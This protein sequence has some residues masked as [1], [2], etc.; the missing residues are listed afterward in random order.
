MPFCK[1]TNSTSFSKIYALT[2]C[3]LFG[4]LLFCIYGCLDVPSSYEQGYM[5]QSAEILLIHNENESGI[6][7]VPANETF[8]LKAKVTPQSLE[9]DLVFSWFSNGNEIAR[10]AIYEYTKSSA[11][12]DS[13]EIHDAAKNSI[14]MA[15]QVIQNSAPIF[16]KLIEPQNGDTL[17]GLKNASYKF[18]WLASDPDND[19]LTYILEIDGKPYPTGLWNSVYQGNIAYGTHSLRIIVNDNFNNSDT[20]STSTFFVWLEDE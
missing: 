5:L 10:G 17:K 14:G 19:S 18:S 2:I 13:I 11:I 7:Q 3:G 1:V 4:I 20:S 8:K 12:P 16:E 15:F 9:P 6:L